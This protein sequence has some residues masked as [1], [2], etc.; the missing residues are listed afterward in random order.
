MLCVCI[1]ETRVGRMVRWWV[2]EDGNGGE[3]RG[4]NDYK[5]YGTGMVRTD[6]D[7]YYR[8]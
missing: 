4:E 8:D 1:E 2:D 5:E 6:T 3:I 7:I